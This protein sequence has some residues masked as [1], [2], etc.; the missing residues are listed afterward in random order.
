MTRFATALV[1]VALG[2]AGFHATDCRRNPSGSTTPDAGGPCDA[3]RAG[4]ARVSGLLAQGKLD[5]ALRVIARSNELC[6]GEAPRTWPEEVTTLAE[7]GREPEALK[8]ADAIDASLTADAAAREASRKARVLAREPRPE[9][10]T[11]VHSG[12]AAR[13]KGDS[14]AAQR[15]FDRAIERL[16]PGGG[17]QVEVLDEMKFVGTMAWSPDG[18][19]LGVALPESV[20]VFDARTWQPRYRFHAAARALAFAPDGLTL[21]AADGTIRL[22]PLGPPVGGV[23]RSI[24]VRFD[25]TSHSVD[26]L[27]FSPDGKT[28]AVGSYDGSVGVVP[29]DSGAPLHI[30]KS[31]GGRADRVALLAFSADSK[32]VR[33][34]TVDGT[35]RTLALDPRAA[36]SPQKLPFAVGASRDDPTDWSFTRSVLALSADGKTVASGPH[37]GDLRLATVGSSAPPRVLWP[38]TNGDGAAFSPDGKALAWGSGDAIH[39][40]TLDGSAPQVAL[41]VDRDPAF[42]LAFSPD[43]NTLASGQHE[44]HLWHLDSASAP[45]LDA[46]VQATQVVFSP[47]GSTLAVVASDGTL[48]LMAPGSDTG[49]RAIDRGGVP[50]AR[51]LAAAFSPDSKTVASGEDS[52]MVYL[53]PVRSPGPPRAFD[54]TV[55]RRVNAVAFAPDGKMLAAGSDDRVVRVWTLHATGS[56]G[57]SAPP[58][59]LEG[60]KLAVTAVAFSPDGATLASGSQDRSVRLWPLA[61]EAT[62]RVLEDQVEILST[63]FSPDGKRL[64]SGDR[65]WE[66]DSTATPRHL[67]GIRH[68]FSADGKWIGSIV[69]RGIALR[70][71]VGASTGLTIVTLRAT[72]GSSVAAAVTEDGHF[73]ILGEKA[74]EY[75]VCVAGVRVYPLELCEERFEVPDLV[76]RVVA[77]DGSYLLP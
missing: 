26:V 30:L 49:P 36:A 41:H 47:D 4:R 17:L 12:L 68:V 64:A 16:R 18:R 32:A 71:S 5:R 65:L 62:P 38:V 52:G 66:L 46:S 20:V 55:H 39:V 61:S 51:V 40:T 27:A 57:A 76:A 6:P 1:A 35:V 19:L 54:T 31:R 37:D 29:A 67:E 3:A 2:V 8:L 44:L 14:P 33:A 72:D 24:E 58:R 28:L 73:A 77:Q 9:A 48:R 63:A 70:S 75:V 22:L 34:I 21:A 53:W 45:R 59:M 43:G 11:L 69:P 15:S 50:A 60:H 10:D 74:R 23:P 25:E 13:A 7:I 42:S 56:S